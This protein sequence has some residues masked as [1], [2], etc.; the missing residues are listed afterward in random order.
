MLPAIIST[1]QREMSSY[2]HDLSADTEAHGFE[3]GSNLCGIDT[4]VKH[5][6]DIAC[7]QAV[8]VCAVHAVVILNEAGLLGASQPDVLAPQGVNTLLR[9]VGLSEEA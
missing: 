5:V 6:S 9:R 3:A 2:P 7:K 1:A 4:S 8:G